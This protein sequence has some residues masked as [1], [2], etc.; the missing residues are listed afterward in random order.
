MNVRNATLALA[1]A[2]AL[3]GTSYGEVGIFDGN[4]DLGRPGQDPRLPGSAS[5]DSGTGTYTVTGGGSD[6]WTAGEF[7][8]FVYKPLAGDFRIETN[9]EILL[10]A[11]LTKMDNWL[12][13]GLAI[14]NDVDNGSGNEREI[15]FSLAATNPNR[16][17]GKRQTFQWRLDSA[18]DQ[19]SSAPSGV[20]QPNDGSLKLALQRVMLP[21][22]NG[23]TASFIEGFVDRGAGWVKL[24]GQWSDN[25]AESPFVGLML[26]AHRNGTTDITQSAEYTNVTLTSPIA[27]DPLTLP[28][29][30]GDAVS[31]GKTPQ[32]GLWAI[33][34][35][36]DNGT[37]GNIDQVVASLK[38]GTGT[39]VDHYKPTL[40][41][42]DS[43]GPGKFTADATFGVVEEGIKTKGSVDQLAML[44]R[45]VV[46]VLPGEEGEYTFATNSDDGFELAVN[47][48]MVAAHTAGRT[49]SQTNGFGTVYLASGDHPIQFLY[50]EG[51]GSAHTELMV[52]KGRFTNNNQSRAWNLVGAAEIPAGP[53]V[54]KKAGSITPDGWDV[55][56]LKDGATSLATAVTQVKNYWDTGAGTNI[57]TA[58]PDLINY[59]DPNGGGGSKLGYPQTPFPGDNPSAGDDKIA[60]GAK[61]TLDITDPGV[62]TFYL[63]ADDGAQFRMPDITGWSVPAGQNAAIT[64]LT[65]GFQVTSYQSAGAFG[66]IDLAAGT[67]PIEAI[68]Y[69]N[70]GGSFFS[71]W[72]AYGAYSS[73]ND[74]FQLLGE[75]IDTSVPM[76]PYVPAGLRLVP[77]PGSLS[78]LGIGALAFGL[79]RRRA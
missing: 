78:L 79:R 76:T 63:L 58:N 3:A 15:G 2:L 57:H 5:Y 43:G 70:T 10:P 31:V 61:A 22:A 23:E 25:L 38:S 17:D 12:K 69:E 39:I 16:S 29:H 19:Y 11:D 55:V 59:T 56:V 14:R 50:W 8:H 44:A 30:P 75:N 20:A 40:N 37:M 71:I 42:V 21:I 1:C 51:S 62:Y 24:G 33:R 48:R 7:G 4:K 34:E 65:D 64:A 60:L 27:P 45:G 41:I 66:Q 77:E 73:F 67:Y 54:A 6:W 74:A 18:W 26:T 35:V 47:G 72:A 68:M 32:Q 28:R 13:A 36:T 46:R 49:D 9:I 52:A 53:I